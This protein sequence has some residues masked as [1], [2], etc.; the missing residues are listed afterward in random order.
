MQCNGLTTCNRIS[1]ST[2]RRKL[3]KETEQGMEESSDD[4]DDEAATQ[5]L[6]N[7]IG[8]DYEQRRPY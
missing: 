6:K 1:T 5:R 8:F 4:D 7:Y 3:P 2:S